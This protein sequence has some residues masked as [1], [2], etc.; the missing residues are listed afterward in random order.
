MVKDSSLVSLMGVWEISYRAIKIGRRYFS[1]LEML[2][3]AALI[4]W[5]MC[6]IL[7]T[8]QEKIERHMARGERRVS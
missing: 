4:Y 2:V 3:M 1:S 5:V 8:N 7:Q 6:I